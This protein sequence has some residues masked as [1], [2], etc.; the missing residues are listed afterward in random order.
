MTSTTQSSYRCLFSMVGKIV[1]A[2]SLLVNCRW[3]KY[4]NGIFMHQYVYILNLAEILVL[5]PERTIITNKICICVTHMYDMEDV[6]GGITV[7]RGSVSCSFSSQLCGSRYLPGFMFRGG[8]LALVNIA[9]FIVLM[10]SWDSLSMA[11][12]LSS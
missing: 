3:N 11:E 4:L 2:L 9:S 12:K 1:N 10:T 5:T 8:S 7:D 6:E